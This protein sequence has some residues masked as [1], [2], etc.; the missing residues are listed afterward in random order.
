MES[1]R[2]S[3]QG[4]GGRRIGAGRKKDH[5]K[6]QLN[7]CLLNID[8][9]EW[10]AYFDSL[11]TST[12]AGDTKAMTLLFGY[13]FGKPLQPTEERGAAGKLNVKIV[14]VYRATEPSE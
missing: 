1:E 3:N 7:R 4:H 2:Q 10:D 12:L 6:A 8:D 14:E 13:A 9:S 11:K 5:L